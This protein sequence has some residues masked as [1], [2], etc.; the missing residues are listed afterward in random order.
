LA[1]APP[2][3]R[4]RTSKNLFTAGGHRTSQAVAL[5]YTFTVDT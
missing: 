4:R 5:Q 1:V 2:E 3:N